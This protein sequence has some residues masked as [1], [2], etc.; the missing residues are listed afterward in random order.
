MWQCCNFEF[1]GIVSRSES[2]YLGSGGQ[3]EHFVDDLILTP[4]ISPAHPSNVLSLRNMW[5][6]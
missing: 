2:D 6:A 4:H 3:A 1:D 5:I